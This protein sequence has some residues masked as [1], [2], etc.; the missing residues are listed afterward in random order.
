MAAFVLLASCPQRVVASPV[1]ALPKFRLKLI[2]GTVADSRN[3]AAGV[4][5][6]DFWG[7]WCRPCLAEIPSYNQ[8]Y[9][10]YRGKGVHFLT[11]AADSGTPE[12]IRAAARRLKIAYPV[13]TPTWEE[14]DLFG[15]I[16][17]FP[18][19][20]IFDA[21]GRL[22][23]EFVGTNPGKHAA[24]RQIVDRLLNTK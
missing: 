11:L 17:A 20:L 1:N 18:T 3:L 10:D 24:I 14:L 22:V 8:F 21:K 16:E 6:I 12:E 19:T 7:T 9:E 5:V 23:K 15:N 4:T 2:D 13:A